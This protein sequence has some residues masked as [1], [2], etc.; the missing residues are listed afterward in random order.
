MTYIRNLFDRPMFGSMQVGGTKRNTIKR[1]TIKRKMR[2]KKTMR[3][4]MTRY[5]SMMRNKT[6]QISGGYNSH[7]SVGTNHLSNSA[8]AMPPPIQIA[9]CAK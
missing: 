2:N 8:L 7:Y 6:R 9:A 1:R 5:K 3:L 4:A